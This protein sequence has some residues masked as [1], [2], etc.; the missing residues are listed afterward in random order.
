MMGLA[1]ALIDPGAALDR[2]L[3]LAAK[4]AAFPQ[5]CL[6]ADRLASYQQWDLPLPAALEAEVRGGLAVIRSAETQAGAARFAAGAG[7]H[8][9]LE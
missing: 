5:R 2:A 9:T 8:G 1:N 6:R 7:R 3:E 4:L